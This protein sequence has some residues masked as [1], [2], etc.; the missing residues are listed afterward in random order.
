MPGFPSSGNYSCPVK[1]YPAGAIDTGNK[2]PSA[3]GALPRCS[4]YEHSAFF[5]KQ[6]TSHWS[7]VGEGRASLLLCPTPQLSLVL[8]H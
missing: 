4:P 1:W 8:Q 2:G 5:L 6:G 3:L 7:L